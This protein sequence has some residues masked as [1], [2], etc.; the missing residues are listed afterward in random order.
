MYRLTSAINYFDNFNFN[1]YER[2]IKAKQFY[3]EKPRKY[4]SIQKTVY[5]Y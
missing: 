1:L 2:I 3:S 5:P 4:L